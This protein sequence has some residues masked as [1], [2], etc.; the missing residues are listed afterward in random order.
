MNSPAAPLNFQTNMAK[1]VE[2]PFPPAPE[3][4]IEELWFWSG[5]FAVWEFSDSETDVSGF[6]ELYDEDGNGVDCDSPTGDYYTPLQCLVIEAFEKRASGAI[7]ALWLRSAHD[8]DELTEAVLFRFP[9]HIAENARRILEI[10]REDPSCL[11]EEFIQCVGMLHAYTGLALREKSQI[12]IDND[13]RMLRSGVMGE[14]LDRITLGPGALPPR[15]LAAGA[16]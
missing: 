1:L 7:R 13:L 15:K 5:M 11:F 16:P 12:E 14:I 3:K 8:D 10:A 9:R 4:T 6:F 2:Y